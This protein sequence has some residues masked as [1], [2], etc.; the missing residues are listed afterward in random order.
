MSVQYQIQF[1]PQGSDTFSYRPDRCPVLLLPTEE[2]A[3]KVRDVFLEAYPESR[4]R[5]IKI[6][7]EEVEIP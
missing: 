2:G 5:I 6:T 7:H 4:V 1:I 3:K